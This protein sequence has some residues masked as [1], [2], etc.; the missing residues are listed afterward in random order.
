MQGRFNILDGLGSK[1]LRSIH[2]ARILRWVTGFVIMAHLGCTFTVPKRPSLLP[3][4]AAAEE[5]EGQARADW[6][7]TCKM[8][9]DDGGTKVSNSWVGRTFFEH[10]LIVPV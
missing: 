1:M 3:R 9:R 10:V 4:A 6:V 2:R 7:I 5:V 8:D